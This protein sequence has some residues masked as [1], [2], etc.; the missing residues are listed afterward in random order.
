MFFF[1]LDSVGP[2]APAAQGAVK[3]EMAEKVERIRFRLVARRSQLTKIDPA[4]FQFSGD[5]GA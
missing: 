5:F 2:F 1:F 3:G 4:F